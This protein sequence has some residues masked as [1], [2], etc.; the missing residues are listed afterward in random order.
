MNSIL[1][2]EEEKKSV[3]LFSSLIEKQTNK[4]GIH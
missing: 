3:V 4:K 1:I 2:E